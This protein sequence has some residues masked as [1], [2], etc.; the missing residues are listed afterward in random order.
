MKLTALQVAGIEALQVPN[1]VA[2][3]VAEAFDSLVV[4]VVRAALEEV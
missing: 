3:E 4:F 1:T 2:L